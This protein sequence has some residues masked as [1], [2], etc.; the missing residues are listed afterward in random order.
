MTGPLIVLGVSRSGTTLLRVMLDRSPG[1]ALPDESFFV[2]L[3]ARRHGRTVEPK[4]FL[5]DLSRIPNLRA[6]G[7]SPDEVAPRLWSGM[8]TG[9]A[10]SAIFESYA[11]KVGKPRWGDKTPMYMRHLPLLARLFPDAQY[12]H[13]IRDGR[14]AALSFLEMP[15]GTFTRTWAHPR[16]AAQF[17]CLWRKEV[18]DARV[19]G[20]SVGPGR[21]LEV[22]YEELV[23]AT[24]RVVESI[25]G[26]ASLLF[27]P[28]MVEYAG[29]VDVSGKPHQQRLLQSPTVGVRSWRDD[30]SPA[31]ARAF[32]AIA[33]DRLSELGYE[34]RD[35]PPRSPSA[36]T[37][38]ALRWYDVRLTA[39]NATAS[40][41]QRSPMWRR[42]HPPLSG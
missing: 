8:K 1:I 34:L 11:T 6:W 16:D 24:P 21:Y 12:V 22:R 38:L 26:F 2:P 40:A 41:L 36:R 32:E 7:V 9:E 13:L 15:E 3:L 4:G 14:D 42:R 20:Q 37:R 27:E 39:W 29:A 31:D 33:G 28:E 18:G 23:T 25:C 30:M 10:I 35:P 19:L 5:D 17:A